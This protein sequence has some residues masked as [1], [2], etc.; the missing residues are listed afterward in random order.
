MQPKQTEVHLK[1]PLSTGRNAFE[2]F[3]MVLYIDYEIGL[4]KKFQAANHCDA[5][6]EYQI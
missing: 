6:L 4:H 5:Y 3:C 2:I 1:K